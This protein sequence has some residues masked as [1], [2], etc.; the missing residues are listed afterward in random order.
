MVRRRRV[1]PSGTNYTLA[2]AY[3]DNPLGPFT[4]GGTII[5]GRGRDTDLQGNP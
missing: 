4:Y 2:Y 5:D 3:S 1:G